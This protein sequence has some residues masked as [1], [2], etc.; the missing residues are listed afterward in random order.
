MVKLWYKIVWLICFKI[1]FFVSKFRKLML[2]VQNALHGR[3]FET[4]ALKQ[5]SSCQWKHGKMK[6]ISVEIW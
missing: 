5:Y 1:W 6:K 2:G 4:P 3:V